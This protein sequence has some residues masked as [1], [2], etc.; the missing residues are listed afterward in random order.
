MCLSGSGPR[1]SKAAVQHGCTWPWG[2]CKLACRTPSYHVGECNPM[3]LA[4]PN[5]M[6]AIAALLVPPKMASFVCLPIAQTSMHMQC[7]DLQAD[8]QECISFSFFI[9]Y[10]FSTGS[11]SGGSAAGS[12][13]ASSSRGQ[14][15]V[16]MEKL[17][18]IIHPRTCLGSYLRCDAAAWVTT[19]CLS[20]MTL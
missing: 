11:S 10:D 5:G 20:A 15:T 2:P 16:R 7:C 13:G 18:T 3:Y 12:S 1:P 6:L 9:R 14:T 4:M 19:Q 8:P 17:R